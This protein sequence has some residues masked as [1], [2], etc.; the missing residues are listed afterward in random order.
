VGANITYDDINNAYTNSTALGCGSIITS[1]NQV[2]LGTSDETVSI[3][4]SMV[5]SNTIGCNAINSNTMS[6]SLISPANGNNTLTFTGNTITFDT[7][8]IAISGSITTIPLAAGNPAVNTTIFNSSYIAPPLTTDLKLQYPVHET[9][10]LCPGGIDNDLV[11]TF[12]IADIDHIGCKFTLIQTFNTMPIKNI[13][14]QTQQP[15]P[16]VPYQGIWL[17]TSNTTHTSKGS[18]NG[19]EPVNNT[20]SPGLYLAYN[21][22]NNGDLIRM[23]F[24]CLP[25]GYGSLSNECGWYQL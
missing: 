24:I 22:Q 23:T 17:Y 5:C 8:T 15:D 10:I 2:V 18:Y 21:A 3:P 4:G 9:Y 14:F 6:C 20:I 25:Q 12:P 19:Y 11:I 16:S 7:E 1:S 13:W